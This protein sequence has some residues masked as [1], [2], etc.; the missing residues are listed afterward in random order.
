MT[1]RV[2]VEPTASALRCRAPRM[3]GLLWILL[4]G[5]PVSANP[6]GPPDPEKWAASG[7]V[8]VLDRVTLRV[9]WFESLTKLREAATARAVHPRD[10]RGFSILSR[11]QDTGAYVCDVFVVKL[12]GSQIDDDRTVTFGHEVLH[13]FGLSHR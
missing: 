9:H 8:G 7:T 2:S 3:L 10:L 6:L 13:C 11:N 4:A 12:G 5:S 1:T